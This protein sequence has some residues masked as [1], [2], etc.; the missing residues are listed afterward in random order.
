MKTL[1]LLLTGLILPLITHGFVG[2]HRAGVL[3]RD[4]I[5]HLASSKPVVGNQLLTK[6]VGTTTLNSSKNKDIEGTGRG[7]PILLFVLLVNLWM[8]SIPV[9]FRREV[10]CAV[11]ACVENRAACNDCVT[12]EEWKT[13]ITD[14]YR[15]GG[16]INFDFSIDPRTTAAW[17]ERFQK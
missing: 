7:T 12:I 2:N 3:H 4:S 1:P 16:G 14:Y 10:L 5:N 11:P 9:H 13:G 15:N 6:A 17:E 8:F